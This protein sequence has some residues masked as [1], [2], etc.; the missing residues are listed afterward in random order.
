M[1]GDK[2]LDNIGQVVFLCQFQTFR[3]MTDDHLGT[4][5]EGHALMGIDARLVLREI[6][7]VQD[8]ADVVV[9]GSGTHEL[10]LCAD[11]IGNLCCK[12]T[13]LDGMLEGAGG[14]LAHT[15]E[16]FLVHI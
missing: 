16:H 9:I 3:H 8:L 5:H 10:A 11:L 15:T 4:L 12:V 6:D 2:V 13:H 14:Y 7:G 1:G